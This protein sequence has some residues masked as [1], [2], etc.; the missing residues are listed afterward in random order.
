LVKSFILFPR[1]SN[2]GPR[3]KGSE[4]KLNLNGTCF[5]EKIKWFRRKNSAKRRAPDL[6]NEE[7][8]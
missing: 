7:S 1:P 2:E 3:P 6:E 5:G 8:G 4:L